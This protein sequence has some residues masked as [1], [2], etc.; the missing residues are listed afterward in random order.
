MTEEHK[1][2]DEAVEEE[3]AEEPVDVLAKEPMTLKEGKE[4]VLA[5]KEEAAAT[6]KEMGSRP[7]K[8]MIGD[9]VER[10]VDGV[11]GAAD[12]LAGLGKK[13]REK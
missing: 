10:V 6:L 8:Q 4:R 12:G 7:W 2:E 5:A 3:T 9:Y 1:T 13:N 11:L